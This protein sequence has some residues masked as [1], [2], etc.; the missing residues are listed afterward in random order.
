MR[1]VQQQFDQ[2]FAGVTGR[3]N[4][5]HFFSF[6]R[7]KSYWDGCRVGDP[8]FLSGT[9]ARRPS[10]NKKPRRIEPAGLGNFQCD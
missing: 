1:M 9:A 5:G 10:Q 2:F 7:Q 3:A 8:N 4:D 6:H